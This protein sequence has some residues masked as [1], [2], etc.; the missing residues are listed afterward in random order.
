MFLTRAKDAT[1]AS[2]RDSSVEIR[3]IPR[4]AELIAWEVLMS[5][6]STNVGTRS[7]VLVRERGATVRTLLIAG[8]SCVV[9]GLSSAAFAAGNTSTQ[10]TSG[11][12]STTGT[13]S[14]M[15]AQQRN[16]Q[17]VACKENEAPT[18][19]GSC[20]NKA[21]SGNQQGSKQ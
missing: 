5:T 12:T 9:L 8:L 14:T 13:T 10:G 21:K 17:G 15:S 7:P 18:G 4:I 2:Q 3:N 20:I 6:D 11:D 16:N 19:H 1:Y